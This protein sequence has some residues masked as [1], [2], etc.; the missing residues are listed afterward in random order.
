MRKSFTTT[1][2]TWALGLYN[3]HGEEGPQTTTT[4]IRHSLCC[5]KSP[6]TPALLTIILPRSC[7]KSSGKN[8]R[9]EEMCEN[10][11]TQENPHSAT[12]SSFCSDSVLCG[13]IEGCGR[14]SLALPGKGHQRDRRS[15]SGF[16]DVSGK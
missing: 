11:E 5:H 7:L 4:W 15:E 12:L 14:T 2:H 9:Q 1:R 13:G 16:P 3:G 6:D 8:E 10:K